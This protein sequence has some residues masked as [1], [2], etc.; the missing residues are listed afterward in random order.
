MIRYAKEFETARSHL[1]KEALA[2]PHAIRA[3]RVQMQVYE[4]SELSRASGDARRVH[5]FVGH[6]QEI[7][8]G[9]EA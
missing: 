4:Q 7:P 2:R 6:A 5:E 9:A 1:I 3:R 8:I